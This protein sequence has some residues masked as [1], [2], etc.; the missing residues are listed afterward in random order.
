MVACGWRW[1]PGRGGD[2]EHGCLAVEVH[3][4]RLVGPRVGL[5]FSVSQLFPESEILL[6]AHLY[7][8]YCFKLIAKCSLPAK[9][10]CERYVGSN[11][12]AVRNWLM[13][14][15]MFPV[16]LPRP[17]QS[18]TPMFVSDGRTLLS[19]QRNEGGAKDP[20][21]IHLHIQDAQAH[22]CT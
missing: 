1:R 7:R 16:V 20:S 13:A 18:W 21:T 5:V 12:I 6:T 2:D 4:G 15:S 14:K 10:C 3:G 19:R 8:G 11:S 9:L 22:S 17:T